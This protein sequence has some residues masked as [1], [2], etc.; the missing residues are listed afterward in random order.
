M[1]LNV[2]TGPEG[3]VSVSAPESESESESAAIDVWE[4]V[5]RHQYNDGRYPGNITPDE[6][7]WRDGDMEHRIGSKKLTKGAPKK[8]HV[9]IRKSKIRF[10]PENIPM[11]FSPAK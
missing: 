2:Q 7:V 1:R 8:G 9:E 4:E 3:Q 6:V 5:N 11:G 10:I